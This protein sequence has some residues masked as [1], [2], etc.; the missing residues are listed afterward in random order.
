MDPNVLAAAAQPAAPGL[1]DWI[2][3][4]G[5]IVAFFGQVLYWVALVVLLAYAVWQYKRWVNFQLGTG[6]SGRLRAGDV[7]ADD[8]DAAPK[9]K[10]KP[11]SIEEFVE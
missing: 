11:V 9:A 5:N 4:Y 3:Q 10:K 7:A 1:I 6:R 2:T 8:A